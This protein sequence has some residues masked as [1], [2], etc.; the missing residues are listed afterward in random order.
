MKWQR[1]IDLKDEYLK[2][3]TCLRFHPCDFF[4]GERVVEIMMCPSSSDYAVFEFFVTAGYESG[5]R[6]GFVPI[7]SMDKGDQLGTSW[8]IENWYKYIYSESNL[9]DVYVGRKRSIK[10]LPFEKV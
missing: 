9:H 1:L 8:L 5:T 2:V 6:I 4:A 7:A 10:K 3:G